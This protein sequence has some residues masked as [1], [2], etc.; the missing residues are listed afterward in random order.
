[1]MRNRGSTAAT[2]FWPWS[3]ALAAT[4]GV[5]L[6]SVPVDPRCPRLRHELA[7]KPDMSVADVG[8]GSGELTVALAVEV[9]PG[10]HVFSTEI[11]SEAL[12][13]IGNSSAD[14]KGQNGNSG[15]PCRTMQPCGLRRQR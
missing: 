15:L 8:A 12:K 2:S 5:A 7:L 10:G 1:M 14:R 11:D 13:Q 6:A 9:G 3:S 4:A